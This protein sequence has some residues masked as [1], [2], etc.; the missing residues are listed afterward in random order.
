MA[1]HTRAT[2]DDPTRLAVE[3]EAA[4]LFVRR[5]RRE[6]VITQALGTAWDVPTLVEFLGERRAAI[7]CDQITLGPLVVTLDEEVAG[8][9]GAAAVAP[10]EA[11][12][13]RA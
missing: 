11:V 13:Y 2:A 6:R 5:V 7:E 3:V 12:G 8:L 9:S 10:A 4:A 1:A